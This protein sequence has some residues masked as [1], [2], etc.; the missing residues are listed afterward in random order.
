MF[1]AF[2]TYINQQKLFEKTDKILLAVSGGLDSV[3]MA[4]LFAKAKF[5]FA[6]A[7]CNFGL[8]AEE[9]DEDEIFVKKLAQK[10][11]VPFY[12]KTFQTS[13]YAEAQRVSTQMAARELRYA[14]F[15]EL[16][17]QQKLQYVATAQHLNDSIETL[18]LNLSKGAGLA[19]FHGILPKRGQIIRPILFANRDEIYD[20]LV[21]NQLIWREDSSNES[22]KYQRNMLRHQV[23]PVLKQL[24][25]SLEQS[26]E[27][28]IDIMRDVETHWQQCYEQFLTQNISKTDGYETI[29][30]AELASNPALKT[31]YSYALTQYGF[32][33]SQISDILKH[34]NSTPGNTYISTRY[35]LVVDRQKLAITPNNWQ[36]NY[37]SVAVDLA[38]LELGKA[39]I[40]SEIALKLTLQNYEPSQKININKKTASLD[41]DSL[42]GSL[43]VRYAKDGDWF[44]PLGMNGKKTVAD[45][46]NEQKV[47]LNMKHKTQLVLSGLS[48]AWIVG[49]RIDNRFKISEKTQ[50]ILLIEQL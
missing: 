37:S 27:R 1:E 50:K 42:N 10:Y 16:L 23:V 36:A 45:F 34:S 30:T 13:A 6:I 39:L 25:P 33:Y 38:Q 44:C 22:S 11:K 46:L 29:L 15:A 26:I 49:H 47:P 48:I 24:N 32:N 17:E 35:T 7:H 2:L 31:F 18:L 4:D 41:F 28:S 8:R 40:V 21:E 20:Y 12:N 3:V 19:G 9:S 14:W 5:N 43:N